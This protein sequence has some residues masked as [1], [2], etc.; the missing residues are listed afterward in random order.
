PGTVVLAPNTPLNVQSG[1]ETPYTQNYYVM[2]Q[3]DMTHGVLFDVSYVGNV[4]RQLPFT[5][6][7][8]VAAPG[9]GLNGLPFTGPVGVN[10][11]GTGLT[12]NYN[13]LQVNLSKRFSH[14]VGLPWPARGARRS[15]MAQLY[16][17]PSGGRPT[18]GRRM[19]TARRC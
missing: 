9:T 19:G 13:A 12:S 16:S 14:G 2:V 8:N 3:Q 11:V 18:T 4:G 1:I 5:Q 17:I 10:E 7:L 6:A 15:I